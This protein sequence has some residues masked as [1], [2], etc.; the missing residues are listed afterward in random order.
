MQFSI[1]S[2]IIKDYGGHLTI[3]NKKN[4]AWTS[5]RAICQFPQADN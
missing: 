3:I 1:K 5:H 2:V 4:G